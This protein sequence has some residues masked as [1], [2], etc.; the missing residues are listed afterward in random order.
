MSVPQPVR[1]YRPT[2]PDRLAVI[3]AEPAHSG[4]Y[5]IR[6]AR[7]VSGK[8]LQA[9]TTFGPV[10]EADL[11]GHFA[12][13]AAG[14]HQEGFQAAGLGDLLTKLASGNAAVRSRAA[15]LLGWRRAR[16]AVAPLL[17]LLQNAVDEVCSVVD[18]LGEIGD[19]Q[20]V[21]ALRSLAERKLLSRRRSAVE[22]LRKLGD[23]AGLS[24]ALARTRQQLDPLL[25]QALQSQHPTPEQILQSLAQVEH[26]RQGLNLDLLYELGLPECVESVRQSLAEKFLP[27]AFLWRYAKSILKRAQ[28]RHD[29][30][31]LGCLIHLIEVR[32]QA[33]SG[34]AESV[35]SGYDGQVRLTSIFNRRTQLY[36]RRS[37]W[38]YLRRLACHRPHQYAHAA[39]AF[40]IPYT[41]EDVQQPRG[42]R[43]RFAYCYLLNRILY[44][45]SQRFVLDRRRLVHRY[46]PGAS[47]TVG[48]GTREESFPELWDEEPTA[49]LTLL[50]ESP[51][52]EVQQFACSA[53][54]SRHPEVIRQATASQLASMLAAPWPDT[55]W[56]SLRELTRRFDPQSP[57][58]QLLDLLIQDTRP[59]VVEVGR[60]WLRRCV[61]LWTRDSQRAT[62]Y[63]T[64]PD[65]QTQALANELMVAA[66]RYPGEGISTQEHAN[67]RREFVQSAIKLLRESATENI[68]GLAR[69]VR[70][71]LLAE[72]REIL[73]WQ[74][75]WRM[76][77]EGSPAGQSVAA[78][79]LASQPSL[80]LELGH[81]RLEIL[82]NHAVAAVRR[83]AYAL[84]RGAA[85]E[86]AHDFA[87][88]PSLLFALT[89]S[90]WPETRQVALELL[91]SVLDW[92]AVGVEFYLGLLDSNYADV[93]HFGRELVQGY[94]HGLNLA[95]LA[96]RL[97]E[98]P[99]PALREF[100]LD[101]ASIHLS[102]EADLAE[103]E[104]FFRRAIF[105]LWPRRVVKR[106]II[107]FL[108]QRGLAAE[109]Q[110]L[111]AARILA[112]VVRSRTLTDSERALAGLARLQ[113]AYP[114]LREKAGTGISLLL[115]RTRTPSLEEDIPF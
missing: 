42:R 110:A 111:V 86:F 7:G 105:D 74:D 15:L 79:I 25:Q 62:R 27:Q 75:A 93:Q 89:D 47:E 103:L 5:V 57:D 28:L 43:G 53:V 101:L 41:A 96:M 2:G 64:S 84:L 68:D 60:Q 109:S 108:I 13:F 34:I 71:E 112:D 58:W 72:L 23:S 44:G 98:H 107:E 26:K 22:A 78:A 54:T 92:S 37:G 77:T 67:F 81:E 35:K 36:L 18:A 99:Q 61:A 20:A 65:G 12:E 59:Q 30:V 46:R 10:S 39:A 52:Q 115:E 14:L 11:E 33:H 104:S 83:S 56:L 29:W 85:Q 49:Y 66:L 73:F 55:M 38:R 48:L 32:G 113:L 80:A 91:E 6:V 76:I 50:A 51:L 40:L 82:A 70:T 1:L 45:K 3:S 4:G 24:E 19:P 63:L 87:A 100:V 17:T 102:Q 69:I 106:R 95:D 16:E 31:T 88:D 8:Q 21:Q 90:E 9:G 97:T 94:P 114:N